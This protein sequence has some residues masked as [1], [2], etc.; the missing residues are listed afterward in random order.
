MRVLF[1]EMLFTHEMFWSS[2][3]AVCLDKGQVMS[4]HMSMPTDTQYAVEIAFVN[5]RTRCTTIPTPKYG[6]LFLH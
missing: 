1:V 4:A 6:S 3:S 2:C 5:G